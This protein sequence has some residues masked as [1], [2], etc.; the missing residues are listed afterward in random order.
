MSSPLC[1]CSQ[2]S[3]LALLSFISDTPF[4]PTATDNPKTLLELQEKHWKPLLD[5]ARK[6]FKTD[7]RHFESVMITS[8]SE[9]T[10]DAFRAALDALDPWQFAC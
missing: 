9:E 8:Q 3:K 10:K 5:W 6:E 2:Y 4:H 1:V 7:V